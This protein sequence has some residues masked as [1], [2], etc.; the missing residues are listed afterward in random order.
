MV[1]ISGLQKPFY[2]IQDLIVDS[3]IKDFLWLLNN[4]YFLQINGA[5]RNTYLFTVSLNLNWIFL[6]AFQRFSS[7]KATLCARWLR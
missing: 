3:L 1:L 2:L 6:K 5:Y 7:F 4:E